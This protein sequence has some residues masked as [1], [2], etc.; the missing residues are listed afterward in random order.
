M[1]K[2]IANEE[3]V[4]SPV[5]IRELLRSHL[6]EMYVH[7]LGGVISEIPGFR[8]NFEFFDSDCLRCK[9]FALSVVVFLWPQNCFGRPDMKAAMIC[10]ALGIATAARAALSLSIIGSGPPNIQIQTG[11][12]GITFDGSIQLGDAFVVD[13]SVPYAWELTG[14]VDIA[15]EDHYPEYGFGLVGLDFKLLLFDTDHQLLLAESGSTF[16]GSSTCSFR[17][18]NADCT[19]STLFALNSGGVIPPA[20]AE[21]DIESVGACG[22]TNDCVYPYLAYEPITISEISLSGFDAVAPEPSSVLLLSTLF[23]AIVLVLRK[24]F[25]ERRL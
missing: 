19:E 13:A 8:L 25:L 7:P 12:D 4:E 21:I 20:T 11:A 10:L 15:V 2:D 1:V 17:E 14:I 6:A 23:I 24:R 22:T 3:Q 5:G 16:G 18:M 9:V